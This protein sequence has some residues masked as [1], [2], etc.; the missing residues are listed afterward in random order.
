MQ[1]K[2][3][4]HTAALFWVLTLAPLLSA[5]LEPASSGQSQSRSSVIQEIVDTAAV[6][7]IVP[8]FSDLEDSADLL[9]TRAGAFCSDR[10]ESGLTNL[11]SSYQQTMGDWQFI[12]AAGWLPDAPAFQQNRIFFLQSYPLLRNSGDVAPKVNALLDGTDPIDEQAVRSQPASAQGLSALELLLYRPE[13]A[14]VAA[15]EDTEEGNRRCDYVVAVSQ[16]I[17][18]LVT[19]INEGWQPFGGDFVGEILDANQAGGVY[20]SESD[21]LNGLLSMMV[22]Q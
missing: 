2:S 6:A 1:K 19:E 4:R 10:T 3:L 13:G 18:R 16:N 15:F 8:A 12:Q 21:V 5:C 9:V 22:T 17:S 20:E 11:K 7:V 14:G